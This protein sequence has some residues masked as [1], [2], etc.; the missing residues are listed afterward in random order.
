VHFASEHLLMRLYQ[1]DGYA[2]HVAEHEQMIEA[3]ES[4]VGTDGAAAIGRAIDAIDASLVSHI[5]GADR[6]LGHYLSAVGRRNGRR[7]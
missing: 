5:R 3:L 1:Y 7:R 4:L 2:A 6:A